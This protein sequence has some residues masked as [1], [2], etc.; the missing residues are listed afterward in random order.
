MIRLEISRNV[1]TA[2]I[3]FSIIKISIDFINCLLSVYLR[4]HNNVFDVISH[5]FS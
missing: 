5:V 2:I 3:L 4:D 1:I